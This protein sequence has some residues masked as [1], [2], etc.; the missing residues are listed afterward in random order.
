MNALTWP[1]GYPLRLIHRVA[2]E[3]NRGSIIFAQQLGKVIKGSRALPQ[4]DASDAHACIG[5]EVTFHFRDY[6]GFT[7]FK[8]QIGVTWVGEKG[9]TRHCFAETWCRIRSRD[10]SFVPCFTGCKRCP[11][12]SICFSVWCRAG[13]ILL[14][15]YSTWSAVLGR[16]NFLTQ[17]STF[18]FAHLA[19]MESTLQSSWKAIFASIN[20]KLTAC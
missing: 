15:F 13:H 20:T 9:E 19:K 6:S 12:V 3:D 14:H 2:D 5:L 1:T 16:A 11:I 8:K 17:P 7:L 18:F 10:A 4:E